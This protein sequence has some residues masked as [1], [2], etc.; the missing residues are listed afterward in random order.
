MSI[1]FFIDVKNDS[2]RVDIKYSRLLVWKEYI[3]IKIIMMEISNFI[4]IF[5]F[6]NANSARRTQQS[7]CRSTAWSTEKWLRNQLF[8]I[9][10]HS[11]HELWSLSCRK[12]LIKTLPT[13]L[14]CHLTF[15]AWLNY[16]PEKVAEG[17]S[18]SAGVY[19]KMAVFA[20]YSLLHMSIGMQ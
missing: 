11:F 10:F 15:N 13:Q 5:I 12:Q 1:Q 19:G 14:S 4:I 6:F 18:H 3:W 17:T 16:W 9:T 20:C 2:W 7:T 8:F